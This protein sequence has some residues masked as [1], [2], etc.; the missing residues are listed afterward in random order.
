MANYIVKNTDL[1][2]ETT[3]LAFIDGTQVYDNLAKTYKRHRNGYFILAP[4]GAGK[5]YFVDNQA[6]KD[7]IDGD[8]L[9]MATKAHP[10][11]EWWLQSLDEI[12]EVERRSDVITTQAKRL[13]FWIVGSDCY[14]ILPDAVVIPDW[15]THK[16]YI[17]SRET[18][19]YDGG[20]TTKDFDNVLR[21]RQYMESFGEKGVPIFQ[22]VTDASNHLASLEIL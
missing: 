16:K 8:T 7:W 6:E 20:A 10:K 11:G 12:N 9:W 14:S 1:L 13:G 19:A 18:S 4:T 17:A 5:T 15:E 21:I 2:D 3:P 22:S